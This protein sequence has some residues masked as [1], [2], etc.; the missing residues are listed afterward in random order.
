MFNS[1]KSFADY[2]QEQ[3]DNWYKWAEVLRSES[4]DDHKK[5]C[6]DVVALANYFEGKY[7]AS[8][9][10]LRYEKDSAGKK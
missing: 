5:T 9:D 2:R 7:D 4:W 1:K 8:I 6:E 3:K 10:L